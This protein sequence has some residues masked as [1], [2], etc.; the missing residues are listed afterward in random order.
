MDLF[1]ILTS[2]EPDVDDDGDD[3][4]PEDQWAADAW[5]AEVDGKRRQPEVRKDSRGTRRLA[6]LMPGIVL[7]CDAQG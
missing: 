3:E 7:M 5:A 1:A 2:V 6:L 4:S